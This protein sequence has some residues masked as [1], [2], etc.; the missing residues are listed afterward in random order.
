MTPE[1]YM[2]NTPETHTPT[3]PDS[4]DRLHSICLRA[5]MDPQLIIKELLE[6]EGAI[7]P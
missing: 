4:Q 2:T 7:Q 5:H 6:A 1:W 3:Q